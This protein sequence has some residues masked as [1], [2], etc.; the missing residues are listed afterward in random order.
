MRDTLQTYSNLKYLEITKCDLRNLNNF[1]DFMMLEE[2]RLSHNNLQGSMENLMKLKQL[3]YI[4]VSHNIISQL[5]KLFPLRRIKK[6]RVYAKFNPFEN[7]D[8]YKK[9]LSSANLNFL[10]EPMMHPLEEKQR[11]KELILKK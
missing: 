2:L 3:K 8:G 11:E 1:P 10:N 6:I 5:N 9:M 7:K 4:D